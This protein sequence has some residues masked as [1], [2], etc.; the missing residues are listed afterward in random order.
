VQL[1]W[2]GPRSGRAMKSIIG[3]LILYQAAYHREKVGVV[4]RGI[5]GE[6]FGGS[7]SVDVMAFTCDNLTSGNRTM[8]AK[9]FIIH[10]ITYDDLEQVNAS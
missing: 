5:V 4:S 6:A 7:T 1:Q 2:L 8:L 3:L 10:A 9:A